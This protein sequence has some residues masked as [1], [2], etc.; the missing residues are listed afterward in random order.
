MTSGFVRQSAGIAAVIINRVLEFLRCRRAPSN[1][2]PLRQ[3][4]AL[5]QARRCGAGQSLQTVL[6]EPLPPDR[7]ARVDL[8]Q[9]SN[10]GARTT[11][12]TRAQALV[13]VQ[14]PWN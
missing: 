5:P 12:G 7:S 8:A 14:R 9:L 1:Q 2:T 11:A 13:R 3:L 4:S 10:A 6:L